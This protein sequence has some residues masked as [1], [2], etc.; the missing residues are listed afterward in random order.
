MKNG[1]QHRLILILGGPAA[2]ASFATALA[3]VLHVAYAPIIPI[4][5]AIG[6]GALSIWA[7]VTE[8]RDDADHADPW[9]AAE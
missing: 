6:L 5:G 7:L 4:A 2:G 8:N 3:Q 1:L 9:T